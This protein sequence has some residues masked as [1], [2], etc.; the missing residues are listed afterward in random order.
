M[1]VKHIYHA[2]CLLPWLDLHNSCPVCWHEL[3]TEDPDCGYRR[4]TAQ[5]NAQRCGSGTSTAVEEGRTGR[6]VAC[7]MSQ[8]SV[9]MDSR[10]RRL[11]VD[12]D[13]HLV[14][15]ADFIC[16]EKYDGM[17]GPSQRV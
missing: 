15:S 10:N 13:G 14:P 6:G 2:D 5:G 12:L 9:L 11:D 4:G 16:C 17:H 8:Q 1:R 7:C 3:L